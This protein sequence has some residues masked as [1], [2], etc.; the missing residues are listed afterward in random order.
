[1]R[2]SMTQKPH[3]HQGFWNYKK[4]VESILDDVSDIQDYPYD[5][6]TV[7]I[8]LAEVY[9]RLGTDFPH[10][11]SFR[12]TENVSVQWNFGDLGVVVLEDS[13]KD[14]INL[15]TYTSDWKSKSI[16][17]NAY[18]SF[19]VALFDTLCRFVQGSKK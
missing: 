6:S 11:T 1:M 8:M 12:D 7:M 14:G 10:G 19:S 15:T 13:W 16:S 17:L 18:N 9:D 3:I 5:L 4:L 2:N